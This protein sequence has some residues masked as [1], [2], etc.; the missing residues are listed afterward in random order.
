MQWKYEN[1][2]GES[3]GNENISVPRRYCIKIEKKHTIF[4]LGLQSKGILKSFSL[5]FP[6]YIL[7]D[8]QS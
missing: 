8:Y 1:Y 2:N 7:P 6:H 3:E 5:G 4:V